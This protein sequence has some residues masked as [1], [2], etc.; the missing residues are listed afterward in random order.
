MPTEESTV[1]VPCESADVV[2]VGS[3]LGGCAAAIPL[4][5]AGRRVIALDRM[6]FPSDQLS[7]HVLMPAGVMEIE[8]MGALRRVLEQCDPSRVRGVR[9]QAETSHA[10]ERWAATESGIDFGLCVPRDLLDV[11][12]VANAREQGVDVRERCTFQALRWR[13]GRVTGVRYLDADGQPHDIRCSLVIGADGRRSP[14]AAA[15]GASRPY[16]MSRNGRGLVFRYVDDPLAGTGEQGTEVYYQ[17]REGDSFGLCFPAAPKGRAL[18]LFMG[19]REEVAEARRD[20]DG[21]WRRKLSQ[22]A[23]LRARLAGVDWSTASKIR[24]TADVTAYFRAS[25]GPGWALVGDAAHFKDPVTAQGMRDAMWMG[26]TL[27]EHVLPQLDDPL[28]ID[29]ATRVWE[30][31]RDRHCLPAWHFANLDTRVETQSPTICEL[32]REGGRTTEPDLSDLFGRGRTLQQI[33]P[34]PRL[35]KVTTKAL[36]SGERPRAETLARALPELRTELEIRRERWRDAFREARLVHGSDHPDPEMPAAPA[37]VSLPPLADDPAPTTPLVPDAPA[38]AGPAIRRRATD[39]R[40][41]VERE[42][43]TSREEVAA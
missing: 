22:H 40:T 16:R 43:A 9:M 23:L 10:V 37:V 6:S 31:E 19:P 15:A 13:G 4:A 24:S 36:I 42:R 41:A 8:R 11:Q 26:R 20:P 34:L 29:R 32:V 12:L 35:L 5:R 28:A 7:T 27:A 3:R 21:Y 14:V 25:S 38:S 30:H 39:R 1:T 2:V 18:V 17:L 33:A